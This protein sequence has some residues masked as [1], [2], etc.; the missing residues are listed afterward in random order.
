MSLI[1]KIRK[2]EILYWN[3]GIID[4]YGEYAFDVPILV[5]ARVDSSTDEFSDDTNKKIIASKKFYLPL[6]LKPGTYL[7]EDISLIA[8]TKPDVN[9]SCNKVIKNKVTPNIRYTETLYV[10]YV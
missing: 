4:K 6:E 1:K 5:K 3:E 10:S 9:S 7:S 8:E 2:Q